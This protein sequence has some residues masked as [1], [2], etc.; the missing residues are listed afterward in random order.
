MEHSQ[1]WS[2]WVDMPDKMT[3]FVSKAHVGNANVTT[4]WGPLVNMWAV[5]SPCNYDLETHYVQ[6]PLYV[7]H[8]HLRGSPPDFDLP[9][10][11]PDN[12]SLTCKLLWEQQRNWCDHHCQQ[13]WHLRAGCCCI[14]Q[15]SHNYRK[16]DTQL[17]LRD[18]HCFFLIVYHPS[19]KDAI[20]IQPESSGK[21]IECT[22]L[23]LWH[24]PSLDLP[25]WYIQIGGK[26]TIPVLVLPAGIFHI[27]T[28]GRCCMV[29]AVQGNQDSLWNVNGTLCEI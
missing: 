25:A 9:L 28:S 6:V 11:V 5:Y 24:Y 23:L 18:Q 14:W 4:T 8:E 3:A 16:D 13:H 20:F 22:L 26:T 19:P 29:R 10:S 21:I 7:D 1:L 15:Q 17:I 2:L 27:F 12:F